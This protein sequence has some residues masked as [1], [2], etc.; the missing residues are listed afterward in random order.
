[1]PSD[2]RPPITLACDGLI[3]IGIGHERG[4]AGLLVATYHVGILPIGRLLAPG[5]QARKG[6]QQETNQN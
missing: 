2:K 5:V 6:N 3:P 1:M 4:M